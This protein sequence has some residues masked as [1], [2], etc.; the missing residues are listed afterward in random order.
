MERLSSNRRMKLREIIELLDAEVLT[1]NADLER[2]VEYAGASDLMSDVLAFTR[3][4]SVLLT[5]L[6]SIQ[7]V[8]T[9]EMLD[10]KAIV[11][12][13]GKRPDANTI[14]LAEEMGLPLFVSSYPLYEAC[15]ILY[16]A[17]LPG[18]LGTAEAHGWD[19]LMKNRAVKT[20]EGALE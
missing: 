12:V 14:A 16:Q 13:R 9:A 1:R 3:P 6:Q 4:G 2:E 10:L 18:S 15:G 5:G 8:R 17:G 20:A 7:V 19:D 11:F